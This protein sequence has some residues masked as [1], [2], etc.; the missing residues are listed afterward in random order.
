VLNQAL[1]LTCCMTILPPT[2]FEYALLSLY[3]PWAWLVVQTFSYESAPKYLTLLMVLFAIIFAPLTFFLSHGIPVLTPGKSI[4][5]MLLA[6][7]AVVEPLDRHASV[8]ETIAETP[9]IANI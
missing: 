5:I 2:S 8:A 6:V 7:I 1:F 3:I 9:M 4:C